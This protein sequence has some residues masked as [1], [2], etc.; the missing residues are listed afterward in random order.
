MKLQEFG[1][2]CRAVPVVF[3]RKGTKLAA[4]NHMRIYKRNEVDQTK[5]EMSSVNNVCIKRQDIG[6]L[7][8]SV[9]ISFLTS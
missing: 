9:A 4:I 3:R 1:L 2:T 6:M 5:Q 7:N 8:I